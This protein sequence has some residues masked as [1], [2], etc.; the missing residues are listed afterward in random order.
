MLKARQTGGHEDPDEPHL[1]SQGRERAGGP[2]SVARPG[3]IIR[4][5]GLEISSRRLD[6]TVSLTSQTLGQC[7]EIGALVVVG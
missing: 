5:L 7:I 1:L 4:Q 6:Y 3:P 2:L